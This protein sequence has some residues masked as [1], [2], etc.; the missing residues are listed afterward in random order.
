MNVPDKL[1]PWLTSNSPSSINFILESLPLP[2]SLTHEILS[3]L[4][5]SPETVIAV[6]WAYQYGNGYLF[7]EINK[8]IEFSSLGLIY[9]VKELERQFVKDEETPIAGY[10]KLWPGKSLDTIYQVELFDNPQGRK[11]FNIEPIS[12][13]LKNRYLRDWKL[14]NSNAI[15]KSMTVLYG[16]D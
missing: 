11:R 3:Y 14:Y 2:T 1:V 13:S 9:N 6:F 7:F 5:L 12:D 16:Y 4:I 8:F 15:Y 10:S